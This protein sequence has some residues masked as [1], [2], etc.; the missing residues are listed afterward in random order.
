MKFFNVDANKYLNH[1]MKKVQK[2]SCLA[3]LQRLAGAKG[4]SILHLAGLLQAA[5]HAFTQACI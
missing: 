2:D 4:S 5:R 1:L 3:A